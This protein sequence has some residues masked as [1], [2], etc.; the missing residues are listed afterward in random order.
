MSVV[1]TAALQALGDALLP[2]TDL[3]MVHILGGEPSGD[4]GGVPCLVIQPIG[5][6]NGSWQFEAFDEDEVGGAPFGNQQ[7][8]QVGEY[9]GD[10]EMVITANSAA[11]REEI[12][13]QILHFFLSREGSPGTQVVTTKPVTVGKHLTLHEANATFSLDKAEWNEIEAFNKRRKARIVANATVPAIILRN[14]VYTLD[15]LVLAITNDLTGASDASSEQ[16]QIHEDGSITPY[17]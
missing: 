6:G 15:V 10:I 8:F 11:Q 12:E 13:E 17:P 14:N 9:T 16:V 7:L 2:E 4:L 1:R 5:M 3:E